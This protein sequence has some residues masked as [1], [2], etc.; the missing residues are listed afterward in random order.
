MVLKHSVYA[1]VLITDL[2]KRFLTCHVYTCFYVSALKGNIRFNVVHGKGNNF[3]GLSS[4]W[5]GMSTPVLVNHI[6]PLIT[7]VHIHLM[8]SR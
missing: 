3:K 2:M 4:T 5:W 7:G 6:T 8:P 1:Q